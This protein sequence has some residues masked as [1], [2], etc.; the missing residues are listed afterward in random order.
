MIESGAFIRIILVATGIIMLVITILSLAKRKMNES[1]C[2]AWGV[3]SVAL[4]LA[5]ALLNPAHWSEYVS[6]AGLILIIIICFGVLYAAYFVSIKISDLSRR[7][8]ELAIQVS[9]LNQENEKILKRLSETTGID[10][11]DL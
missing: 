3:V 5:G 10:I 9:L 6:L 7:N 4:V 11:R 2:L 1:F 8:Q